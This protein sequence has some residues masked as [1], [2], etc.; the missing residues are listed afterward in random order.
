[1][2]KS[3]LRLEPFVFFFCVLSGVLPILLLHY[4]PTL[5]GPAHQ[6]NA[7][8][9]AH[10]LQGDAPLLSAYFE[11]NR[12]ALPNWTGHLFL[13]FF[14]LFLPSFLAEKALLLC[15]VIGLPLTFRYLSTGLH[16]ENKFLTYLIFPFIYSYFFLMGFY[17]FNL[18]IVFLFLAVGYWIRLVEKPGGLRYAIMFILIAGTYLSHIFVFFI[19]VMSLG[20][21]ELP[22]LFS[23]IDSRPYGMRLRKM[24]TLFLL[25]FPLILLS[26]FYLYHHSVPRKDYLP[27]RQLTNYI[28]NMSPLIG[29]S[30]TDQVFCSRSVAVLMLLLTVT[31]LSLRIRRSSSQQNTTTAGK[32]TLFTKGDSWLTLFLILLL[33]YYVLPDSDGNAGFVSMRLC[34]L[35][36]LALAVWLSFQKFPLWIVLPAAAAALIIFQAQLRFNYWKTAKLSPI[37]QECHEASLQIKPNTL[38]MPLDFSGNWVMSHFS[39]Y[40]GHEKAVVI[41]ENYEASTGYFPLMFNNRGTFRKPLIGDNP[42]NS[43]VNFRWK[44]SPEPK[45]V[46][47]IFA[48]GTAEDRKDSCNMQVDSLIKKFYT[49]A[50]KGDWVVLYKLK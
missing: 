46:D 13:L 3:L 39:N 42:M 18:A 35:V 9:I 8:L 22:R 11:F 41:L 24:L 21:C 6:Y 15:Y 44:M 17:N 10:L 14:N 49:P 26:C 48:W 16:P 29:F 43:C 20:L 12:E 32:S 30:Y 50:Y 34:L 4:Y 40:L 45:Q 28:L 5:D 25:T 31:A 23:K 27:A 36:F 1:M 2:P 47:Y 38:I 7:R 37:A 33:L 19:L